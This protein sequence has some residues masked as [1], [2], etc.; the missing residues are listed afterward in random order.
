MVEII[1][2]KHPLIR[3]LNLYEK[4]TDKPILDPCFI[5]YTIK[6]VCGHERSTFKDSY[7][8]ADQYC[9]E[10]KMMRDVKEFVFTGVKEENIDFSRPDII[11][12]NIQEWN[13][14]TK[15][16]RY[17]LTR[18]K[19]LSSGKYIAAYDYLAA[20]HYGTFTDQ[21]ISEMKERAA[22]GEKVGEKVAEMPTAVYQDRTCITVFEVPDNN[23]YDPNVVSLLKEYLALPD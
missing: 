23:L 11:R 16:G 6:F 1:T 13:C 17:L 5:E 21:D 12:I 8:M 4:K 18:P 22:K 3:Y 14:Q 7:S 10:C 2:A 15:A 9:D 20:P 19:K